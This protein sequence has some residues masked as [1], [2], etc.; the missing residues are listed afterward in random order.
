MGEHMT[1]FF[2]S[3]LHFGH[4]NIINMCNRPYE[5]VHHMNTMLCNNWN[6]KVKQSDEVWV[7]G[8]FSMRGDPSKYLDRLKGRL[9]L[10]VGNHDHRKTRHHPRWVSVSYYRE[11]SPHGQHIILSHYPFLTWNGAHRGT[12]H[13]HGHSHGSLGPTSTTRLDVGVDCHNW[14]PLSFREVKK[15][16]EAR[17]YEVVNHHGNKKCE[18]KRRS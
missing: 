6:S 1:T 15:I 3:D 9:H 16:M 11:V 7:L 5:D 10:V 18:G 8:D 2:T 13:L 17:K 4:R 12:W 14:F